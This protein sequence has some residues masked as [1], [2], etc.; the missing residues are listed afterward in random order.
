[1]T[2]F[3][4][5]DKKDLWNNYGRTDDYRERIETVRRMIPA[6]V[7]S[8]VDVGCGSG[9]VINALHREKSGLRITGMDRSEQALAFVETPS[10]IASLPDAPFAGGR[11][12]L[13]LCLEVLEHIGGADYQRSLQELERLAGFYIIAG[14]PFR[15]NL[16]AKEAVCARCGNVSHADGHVR[17]FTKTELSGLF[18]QFVLDTSV[19]IGVM[20][21]REPS[22]ASRLR[23]SIAGVYYMPDTFE[24]PHCGSKE[25]TPFRF[26]SPLP[27]RKA[28][29]LLVR[30]LRCLKRPEPYW[31]IGLYRRKHA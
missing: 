13:V 19:R 18:E 1:M 26:R 20:Q 14:V 15:E 9:D 25:C 12:D 31:W 23:H 21:R 5:F 16:S 24:C 29:G 11:F 7:R 27:L 28:A 4:A 6:D 17:R 22:A 10:V 8:I 3:P 30:L 2:E